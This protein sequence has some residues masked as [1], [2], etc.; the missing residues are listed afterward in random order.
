MISPEDHIQVSSLESW[1]QL[2]FEGTKKLNTIQ[3]LVYPTAYN[4]AENTL[5][6]APTGAGMCISL[7]LSLSTGPDLGH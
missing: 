7:S 4:S 5:V 6:C 3:S 2:A 1:A